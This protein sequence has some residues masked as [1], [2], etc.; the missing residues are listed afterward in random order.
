MDTWTRQPQ[1]CPGDYFF[2]G[3]AFMT[4]GVQAALSPEEIAFIAEELRAF[5]ERENGVDYLQ[6]YEADDSRRVWC[7]DQLRQ[8]VKESGEFTKEQLAE[9]DYWTMLLPEEY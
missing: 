7:I 6:V 8:S 5:V 9:Y 4:V 3:R 1:E 2:S